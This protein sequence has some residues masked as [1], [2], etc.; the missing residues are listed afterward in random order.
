[1]WNIVRRT[2]VGVLRAV[3]YSLLGGAAVAITIGVI[4]LNKRPDLDVWHKAKL[5]EEFTVD[6]GVASFREYLELE[7]R[8]WQQLDELV[9][10]GQP[11]GPDQQTNRYSRGSLS[12]PERWPRNWNRSF[13]LPAAEPRAGVLLLHGMSDS[14]Y[15]LR[16][17]AE[18][19]QRE[20]A[21]VVGLRLPGHGTAPSGLVTASYEDMAAATRL[22]LDHLKDTVGNAPLY[23]V[24]YSNGGALAV[25]YALDSVQDDSL[26]QVQAIILVSPAIG[27]TPLAAFAIWQSRLGNL[28]GLDKLAWNSIGPEYDPF[29]Y[30][31]FAVNAGDQT[32]RLTERIQEQLTS[33]AGSNDLGNLPPILAFQSAVDATVSPRALLEGL[34]FRLPAGNHE[35]HLFDLNRRSEVEP[36]LNYD[37]RTTFSPLLEGRDLGFTLS[38]VTNR[39]ERSNALQLRQIR[40]GS[41]RISETPLDLEWGPDLFSLSHVA[42]PFRPDDPVYGGRAPHALPGLQIGSLAARGERGVLRISGTDMLRLRWNPFY[43]HMEQRMLA[44]MG[45]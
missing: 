23:L 15:S 22:G 7:D 33:L 2:S 31:S 45:L 10:S 36:L 9:I 3:A 28:L 13:E 1:M 26:P 24:G 32:Y 25:H 21:H 18:R 35:L 17:L 41:D 40:P 29:K 27:V 34:F 20:A 19:L 43:D 42:L 6:S 44:F 8:L 5:D 11:T 12:D 30:V 37:P 39:N 14:P 38:V 16:A 4:A